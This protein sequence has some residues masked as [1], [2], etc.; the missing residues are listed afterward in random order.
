MLVSVLLLAADVVAFTAFYVTIRKKLGVPN[1]LSITYYEFEP[2]LRYF[3]PVVNVF[4]CLTGAPVWIYMTCQASEWARYF[5]AVPIITS[6]C[7]LLVAASFDYKRSKALIR[8]HYAVAWIACLGIILW[9]NAVA[10]RIAWFGLS[11]LTAFLLAGIHTKTLKTCPLFWL[12][13]AA[14]N[15]L[16]ATLLVITIFQIQI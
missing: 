10:W 6:I 9:L 13:M 11:I 7:M 8:F 4:L 2:K 1:N 12:E 15:S 5:I 3:F 14:F 16:A